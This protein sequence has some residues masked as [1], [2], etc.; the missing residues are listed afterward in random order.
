MRLA[1]LLIAAVSMGCTALVDLPRKHF[2]DTDTG[3]EADSPWDM[4]ESI[5][6][7]PDG[8][9]AVDQ[10]DV[11]ADSGLPDITEAIDSEMDEEDDTPTCSVTED[12]DG[13]GLSSLGG[14]CCDS[15]PRVH[16]MQPD[17]FYEPYACPEPSWDYDCSGAE[18]YEQEGFR[19]GLDASVG[20]GCSHYTYSVCLTHPEGW[21]DGPPS[22]G[23][24]EVYVTCIGVSGPGYSYCDEHS[25]F[26]NGIMGCH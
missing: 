10:T 22:C 5:D 23:E 17:W 3:E 15:D 16:P 8:I 12:C 26:F 1:L 13:D 21:V 24:I 9:D 19:D 11:P 6:S 20:G 25:T 7:S 14:D 18:E 4:E 2:Q